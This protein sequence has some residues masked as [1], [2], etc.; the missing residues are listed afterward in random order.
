[1]QNKLK[2]KSIVSTFLLV[3][4]VF[5]VIILL[6]K[7]LIPFITA[8]ILTYIFNPFV[9]KIQR[10]L[11]IKRSII[12]ATISIIVFLIFILVPVFVIP[13]MI[14]QVRSIIKEVPGIIQVLN[15]NILS[16]INDQYG[17]NLQFDMNDVKNLVLGNMMSLYDNVNIFSPLARNGILII[18]ILVYIILIPFV[19]FYSIINWH[20]IIKFFDEFIPKKYKKIMY[21]LVKDIDFMLSSYLHGQISVMVIMAIYYSVT[22]HFIGL[23]SGST[24]GILTGMLVFIPYLGVLS[25]LLIS[26]FVSLA[27]FS[28]LH[29]IVMVLIVFG[30][31]HVF[32]GGLVTPFLVG[33]KI[34]LNPIMVIF[35]L[36]VFGKLFGLIGVL[37]ALPLATITVVLLKYVKA[38]YLNSHYY[39]E[40]N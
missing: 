12:S 4:G 32:E 33:G 7:V 6:G 18:E 14:L 11:K 20:H 16:H 27:D 15:S 9:E 10:K 39:N 1:M 24:I 5:A 35:A 38:Y 23:N 37:L 17:T 29:Q 8:L 34:G 3:I 26:L 30:V 40:E 22:L 21:H 31:G 25:G 19:L 13:N 2:L 36:M 28:N